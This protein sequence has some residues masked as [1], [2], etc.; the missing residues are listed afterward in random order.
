MRRSWLIL[1]LALLLPAGCSSN[2]PVQQVQ[3]PIIRVKLLSSVDQVLVSASQPPMVCA[4][5]DAEA[6]TMSF[7]EN[8]KVQILLAADGFCASAMFRPAAA[9]LSWSPPAPIRSW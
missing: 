4:A 1:A 6:H 2:R 3:A 5:S 7:P 8:Q 9:S